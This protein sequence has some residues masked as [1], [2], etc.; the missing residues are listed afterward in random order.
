[1]LVLTQS[2]LL[3]DLDMSGSKKYMLGHSHSLF[4]IDH[5]LVLTNIFFFKLLFL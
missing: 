1:M 2:D 4:G 5:Y 3:L